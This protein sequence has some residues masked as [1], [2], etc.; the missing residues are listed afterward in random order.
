MS[1]KN[2]KAC[3]NDCPLCSGPNENDCLSMELNIKIEELQN[4]F[5]FIINLEKMSETKRR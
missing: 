4:P 1:S 2:C 5:S 3:F